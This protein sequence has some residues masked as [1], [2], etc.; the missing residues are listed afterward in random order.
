MSKNI[1]LNNEEKETTQKNMK[2]KEK[3]AYGKSKKERT[4]CECVESKKKEFKLHSNLYEINMRY[5]PAQSSHPRR[6]LPNPNLDFSQG[7][8]YINSKGLNL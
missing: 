3:V 6:P 1:E 4:P 8:I 7:E 5:V 2:K